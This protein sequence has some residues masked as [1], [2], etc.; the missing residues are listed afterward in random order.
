[1]TLK[2]L[3]IALFGALYFCG[4]NTVNAQNDT[5]NAPKIIVKASVLGFV[6]RATCVELNAE[7]FL[8]PAF[9]VQADLGYYNQ[10]LFNPK[11]TGKYSGV[12]YG[13]ELR[14]YLRPYHTGKIRT[15]VGASV[16]NNHSNIIALKDGRIL[17]NN[18]V[19]NIYDVP[20]Q[21]EHDR[22][23]AHITGGIVFP[24]AQRVTVEC[25]VGVGIMKET[26]NNIVIDERVE[27]IGNSEPPFTLAAW[28]VP[29]YTQSYTATDVNA[30]L[31]VGYILK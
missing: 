8:A 23:Y 10:N 20:V 17:Q 28:K 25:Y 22:F 4:I 2:N 30:W 15:F 14:Y 27:I 18:K 11:L 9:S 5:V 19:T 7:Y 26:P 31:R 24:V 3:L 13:G 21:F 16:L 29:S 1:M 6:E 12:R